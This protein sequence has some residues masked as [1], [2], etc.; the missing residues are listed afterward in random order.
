MIV[1]SKDFPIFD[2][3]QWPLSYVQTNVVSQINAALKDGSLNTRKNTC[4][5]G[6]HKDTFVISGCDRYG[7]NIP[8]VLCRECGLVR[9]GLVFTDE[10]NDLFYQKYYRKLYNA[11]ES[12]EQYFKKQCNRGEHF[13]ELLS[14]LQILDKIETVAEI[15]C[16]SGGVLF[17]L[18]KIGKNVRGY[19]YDE[20]FLEYGKIKGLNLY[21]EDFYRSVENNSIDLVIA[22]HVVE[23]FTNPLDGIVRLLQKVKV[24]GYF[25]MEVPGL[26]WFPPSGF[27][28]LTNFQNAH[29]IQYFYKDYLEFLFQTL[30][31]EILYGD[32]RCT[33]ICRIVSPINNIDELAPNDKLRVCAMKNLDYLKRRRKELSRRV[34]LKTRIHRW[35]RKNNLVR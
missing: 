6:S 7:M 26:Y 14:N 33:F 17:P 1:F 30:G 23:H 10:S 2:E 9:S 12:V 11:N 15:G 34:K 28:P 13:V 35:L 29:V 8:Q 32:E 25:V 16:G 24:G 31:V 27:N 21:Q 22:S 5:C 3:A 20:S 4:V 18:F 19:D